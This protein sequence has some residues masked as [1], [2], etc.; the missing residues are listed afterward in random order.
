MV[1]IAAVLMLQLLGLLQGI[2]LVILASLVLAIGLQPAIKW[3]E[4][5]GLKRGFGLGVVLVGMLVAVGGMMG[6]AF[7]TIVSQFG[8][9]IDRL[10]EYLDQ[11]QAGD[12]L[13]AGLAS[14]IDLEEVAEQA[15]A[16]PSA[17]VGVV[18]G[19][20]SFA[21]NLLTVVVVTPYFALSMPSIKRWSV[22][23]LRPRHRERFLFVLNQA[24]DLMANFI[25]GNLLI[26][27]VAGV[28]TYI[29]LTLIG[30]PYALALA[31]W[32]AVTDLIPVIGA[33]LGA[34]A[35]A[36]VAF[37]AGP[38]DLALSLALIVVYQQVENF[39][40]AP[41]VM[42]HAVNL[43]PAAVIISLMIGG[44]LAGLVG[45]LLALPLAALI[46]IL[47]HEFLIKERIQQVR[48]EVTEPEERRR[49]RRKETRVLP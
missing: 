33:V 28:V 44:R 18:G 9:A 27:L 30:V 8:D 32:V 17:A 29:G 15:S 5:R 26:S 23:L 45:A 10:P 41:R 31:A 2:L 24:T 25:I 12:G 4:R 39:L 37:F 6:L 38:A 36:V 49:G 16:D 19:V 1:L 35:V 14:M 20:A 13:I 46:K 7:P 47:A 11:F 3:F 48:S 34:V 21:L 22:R 42:R 40:I 43:S